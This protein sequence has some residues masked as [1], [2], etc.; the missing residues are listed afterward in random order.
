[1]RTPPSA[2]WLLFLICSV[3]L[4]AKVVV[5]WQD[6]F[7]T[8]DSQPLTRATLERA[9]GSSH[10]SFSTLENGND[11]TSYAANDLLVMPYGSAVP[12]FAF[13]EIQQYLRRGGNLLVLGGQ[14]FRVPVIRSN[15]AFVREQPQEAYSRELGILHTYEVPQKDERNLAG[16]KT[17]ISCL[18][19]RYARGDF[20]FCRGD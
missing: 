13:E 12:A 4:S 10:P 11:L 19:R 20:L 1:M 16:S 18:P 2:K 5:F 15:G 7:P 6:G 3:H 9:F 8:V 14:P 17:M